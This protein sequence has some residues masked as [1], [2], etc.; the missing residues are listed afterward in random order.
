LKTLAEV[1]PSWYGYIDF[2][3]NQEIGMT[4]AELTVKIMETVPA[5]RGNVYETTVKTRRADG[6]VREN[7]PYFIWTRSGGGKMRSSYVPQ[8]DV[9]RYR[10]EI[11]NGKKLEV[12]IR[13]LWRLAEGAAD[14]EKKRRGLRRGRGRVDR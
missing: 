3:Y 2:I 12:L 13:E 11:E 9:S 14:A 1:L 10:R 6:T 7:G 5:R 8:A 4:L